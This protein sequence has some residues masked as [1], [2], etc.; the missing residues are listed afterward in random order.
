MKFA[1]SGCKITGSLLFSGIRVNTFHLPLA[2]ATVEFC[3]PQGTPRALW[4]R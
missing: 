2:E 3:A 4:T 1:C